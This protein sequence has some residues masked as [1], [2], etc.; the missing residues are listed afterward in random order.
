MSKNYI[1]SSKEKNPTNKSTGDIDSL[2]EDITENNNDRIKE[3]YNALKIIYRLGLLHWFKEDVG[4]YDINESNF[5]NEELTAR[6]K[7][8][9]SDY[10]TGVRIA[11][12]TEILLRYAKSDCPIIILG[13]S[14]TGKDILA[15]VINEISKTENN[16]S[17]EKPFIKINAAG[18]TET[19]FESEMF[20]HMKGAFTGAIENKK[21]LLQMANGG[22]FFLDELGKMPI[23]SQAKLL[24]VIQN[25]QVRSVGSLKDDDV[26]VKF[27]AALHQDE[28]DKRMVLP[29]LLYRLNYPDVIRMTSLKELSIGHKREIILSL[30]NRVKKRIKDYE[31]TKIDIDQNLMDHLIERD[32][33]GNY[34]ELESIL[35]HAIMRLNYDDLDDDIEGDDQKEYLDKDIDGDGRYILSMKCIKE[36]SVRNQPMATRN[37]M[38][39]SLKLST[40]LSSEES[41]LEQMFAECPAILMTLDYDSLKLTDIISSAQI[42]KESIIKAMIVYCYRNDEKFKAAIKKGNKKTDYVGYLQKLKRAIGGKMTARKYAEK[43]VKDYGA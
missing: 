1:R 26:K 18:L 31:F 21:G 27:I 9:L 37:G 33:E 17:N 6:I 13:E 10:E 32:Y 34:R 25:N 7:D 2:V 41:Q 30:I 29:D 43:Y 4:L 36:I 28:I 8:V 39:P 20:G 38:Y 42:I 3:I 12:N 5:T 19:L 11:R 16:K 23:S 35:H 14:G 15:E 24:R 22:T 40:V